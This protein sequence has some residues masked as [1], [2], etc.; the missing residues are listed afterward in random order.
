MSEND[1]ELIE[2][3]GKVFRDLGDPAADLKQGKAV[4]AARIIAMLDSG[5]RIT[6]HVHAR[7]ESEAAI[8]R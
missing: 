5:S 2:G 1:F 6:V 4:I 8:A 3:S 7:H